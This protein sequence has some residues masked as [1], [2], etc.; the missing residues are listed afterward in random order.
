MFEKA[1]RKQYRFPSTKG[2]LTVEDLWVIPLTSNR[3]DQPNLDDIARTLFK[4]LKENETESFVIKSTKTDDT[5][6][7][8]FDIVKHIID[9][10][11]AEAEVAKL[12]KENKERKQLILAEIAKR[13]NDFSGSSMEELEKLA[14]SLP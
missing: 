11:L 6:K 5:I 2:N 1:S 8:K 4:E 12:A 7:D 3:K 10:R 9:I 14:D 13:K